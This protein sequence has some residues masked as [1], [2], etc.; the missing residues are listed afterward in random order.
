MKK[1]INGRKYD[2]ETAQEL[3]HY[4]NY[5]SWNDFNHLE[6]GLYR[7]KNGEFFLFGEGGARTRYARQVGSS[8]WSGG[9]EIRPLTIDEAREWAEKH[10]SAD[11][12]ET[13]FGPVSE[14]DAPGK[15]MVTICISEEKW[16]IVKAAAEKKES[17]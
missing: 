9:E 11:E 10:L 14:D 17:V 1:I 12:Y 5:G 15:M 2:T 8:T 6:E 13:I 16:N 7:K 3:G 4:S